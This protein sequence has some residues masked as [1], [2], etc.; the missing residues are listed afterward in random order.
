MRRLLALACAGGLITSA[1]LGSATAYPDPSMF[2][3]AAHNPSGETLVVVFDEKQGG[4][5]K[6]HSQPTTPDQCDAMLQLFRE[7]QENGQPIMLNRL[8]DS[9]RA[10]AMFCIKQD[11]EG[12]DWTGA[13]VTSEQVERQADALLTQPPMD[14]EA[15][16]HRGF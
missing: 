15:G 12:V 4:L 9:V 1:P 10:L 3:F 14:R 8:L 2:T 16:I 6:M 13:A 5:R 7:F 11:G